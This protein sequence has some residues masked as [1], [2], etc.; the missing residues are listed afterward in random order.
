[1]HETS[2]FPPLSTCHFLTISK[3]NYCVWISNAIIICLNLCIQWFFPKCLYVP[4][5]I[6][7]STDWQTYILF[8]IYMAS[9]LTPFP[10]LFQNVFSYSP[11]FNQNLFILHSPSWFLLSSCTPNHWFSSL[12]KTA[13]KSAPPNYHLTTN[14]LVCFSGAHVLCKRRNLSKPSCWW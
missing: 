13:L 2:H 6:S 3:W 10:Q 9:V 8:L 1:M 14:W 4:L 11:S 5:F 7:G 12:G